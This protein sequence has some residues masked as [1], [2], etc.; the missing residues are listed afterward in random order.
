[1]DMEMEI[2]YNDF[3]YIGDNW[4]MGMNGDLEITVNIKFTNTKQ[5]T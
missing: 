4:K 5:N 3:G 1:M 2:I